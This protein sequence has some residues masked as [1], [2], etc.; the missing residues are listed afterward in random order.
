ME[1]G[2]YVVS[3]DTSTH[4]QTSLEEI[5]DFVQSRSFQSWCRGARLLNERS[6]GKTRNQQKSAGMTLLTKTAAPHSIE[7]EDI[8]S[9]SQ[10]ATMME[11]PVQGTSITTMNGANYVQVV[12]PMDLQEGYQLQVE[13]NGQT[14]TVTVPA[15]GVKE[16]QSFQAA[17]MGGGAGAAVPTKD[18]AVH[19]I[20]SGKW[21]D[22]LCECC[23]FGCCQ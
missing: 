2:N 9:Q 11:Q 23:T 1:L 18:G 12:A 8:N 16:G 7:K 3:D 14:Q 22:G 21:R 17:P 15:G 4:R 20:P 13:I 10:Q 19:V 5:M 6:N